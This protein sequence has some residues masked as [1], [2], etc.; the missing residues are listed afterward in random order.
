MQDGAILCD[1]DLFA[2]EHGVNARAQAGFRGKANE[3]AEGLVSNAVLRVIE[4]EADGFQR[5][6]LAPL[7]IFREETAQMQLGN[8]LVMR[9]ERLPCRLLRCLLLTPFR[10][11]CHLLLLSASAT[12]GRTAAL[13]ERRRLVLFAPPAKNKEAFANQ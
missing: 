1:V 8:L 5:Q 3:K 12:S 11:S 6:T 10:G 4:I 9:G 2:T 13:W 7:G